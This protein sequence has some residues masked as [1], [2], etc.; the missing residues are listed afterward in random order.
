MRE[1]GKQNYY[2]YL[3]IEQSKSKQDYYLFLF[4]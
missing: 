3:G 4:F 2:Q 1:K